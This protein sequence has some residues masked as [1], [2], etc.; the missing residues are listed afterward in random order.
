MTHHKRA[1]I[2]DLIERETHAN[3]VSQEAARAFLV[4]EGI[5][6]ANGQLSPNFGG[7][8]SASPNSQPARPS[9]AKR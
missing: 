2:K 3:T 5:Y 8:S 7:P 9:N 6:L 1:A 4:R